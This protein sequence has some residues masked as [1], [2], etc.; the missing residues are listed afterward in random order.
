L[1]EWLKSRNQKTVELFK[2][3]FSFPDKPLF[4]SVAT[5]QNQHPHIRTMRIYEFNQE[6][7]PILLTHTGSNK[8]KDF[9]NHP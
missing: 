4:A 2:E 7:C 5:L 3:H 9:L 6:G 8:Q 1:D